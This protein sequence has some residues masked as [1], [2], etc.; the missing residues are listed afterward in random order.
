MSLRLAWQRW[1]GWGALAVLPPLGLSGAVAWPFLLP[2]ALVA[3]AAVT[4]KTLLRPLPNWLENLLAPFIVAA[5]VAAGGVQFGVLRPVAHLLALLAAVRLFGAAE[6]SRRKMPMVVLAVLG[7]AGVASSTHP[8]LVLYLLGLLSGL[9]AAVMVLLPQELARARGI[10]PPPA[11]VSPRLLLATVILALLVA[12]PIFVAFPR[13]RSP[14]AAAGV[15]ARPVSGFREAVALHRLGEIKTSR[16]PMLRVRFES[17]EPADP[18]WLRFAGATLTHYRAGRWIESKRT[19]SK[20]AEWRPAPA[21]FAAELTLEQASDRLFLPPGT[22]HLVPPSEVK[23]WLDGSEAWRIPRQLEPPIAYRV[24]FQ[25]HEVHT[26]PPTPEDLLVGGNRAALA[27]LAASA[28]GEASDELAKAQAL[29]RYLQTGYRYTLATNAPLGADPVEWF[30]FTARGGHCEFFASAMVLLLRTLGIPAR[31][32]T[33]F[34]GGQSLGEGEFLIRDANAHAWVLAYVRGRWRIFDPTP[35][36][37]RPGLEVSSSRWDPRA[38]WAQMEAFWDRWILTFSLA[39]QLEAIASLWR[40]VRNGLLRVGAAAAVLGLLYALGR[41][42]RR[43]R[44]PAPWVSPLGQL[45]FQLGRAA[46]WE[47]G[48]L[49]RS[50]PRNVMKSLLPRLTTSRDACSALFELHER[51]TYGGGTSPSRR[52]L[53]RWTQEVL[54]ELRRNEAA[55]RTTIEQAPG[56]M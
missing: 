55:V 45:L 32:Q 19:V 5:V 6:P 10:P 23:P 28:V 50:T 2:L 12:V 26:R 54:E 14:F 3:L 11:A 29:E 33:G 53:L 34:A 48:E 56:S 39:D 27:L 46:G 7:V 17:G 18:S 25:P 36:E 51:V 43:T 42:A 37:G 15:G 9:G 16:R 24:R 13:L 4:H 1:L 44:R 49:V 47:E 30:L 40:T 38:V 41:W 35:P 52:Q 22:T 8:S 21:D 31:L 20:P